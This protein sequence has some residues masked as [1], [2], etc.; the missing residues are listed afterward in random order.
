MFFPPT[1]GNKSDDDGFFTAGHEAES[2]LWIPGQLYLSRLWGLNVI[3]VVTRVI[4][5]RV[6]L[7]VTET[8]R[9]KL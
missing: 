8:Q 1:V 7:Y 4:L 6:L 2:F 3:W 5:G 9:L